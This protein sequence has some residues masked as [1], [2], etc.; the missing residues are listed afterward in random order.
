VR[1]DHETPRSDHDASAD[2]KEIDQAI[3]QIERQEREK[4]SWR[5]TVLPDEA[6]I[7]AAYES[8]D[9]GS[10]AK[11]ALKW[12]ALFRI[13]ECDKAPE[14]AG[15]LILRSWNAP[16]RRGWLSPKHAL[17]RDFSAVCRLP[18]RSLPEKVG[19]NAILGSFLRGVWVIARTHLVTGYVDPNTRETVKRASYEHYSVISEITGVAAGSPMEPRY[20]TRRRWHR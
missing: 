12:F 20:L 10:L 14:M 15:R 13:V 8:V 16:R 18:F 4:P 7:V 6:E 2:W 17:A 1:D 3:D 9:T 11:G 19:P 5:A